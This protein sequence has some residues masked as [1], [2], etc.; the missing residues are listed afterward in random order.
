[1]VAVILTSGAV[2]KKRGT[3]LLCVQ[4]EWA[5]YVLSAKNEANQAGDWE[6]KAEYSCVY[7][8]IKRPPKMQ[9]LSGRL[10]VVVAYKNRTTGGLFREEVQAYLRYG[11]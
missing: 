7:C 3:G 10:Q 6:E 1:M 8:Y 11:K 2:A 5:A 4:N 9:R